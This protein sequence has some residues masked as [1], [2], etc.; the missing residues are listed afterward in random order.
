MNSVTTPHKQEEKALRAAV[1]AGDTQAWR[2]LYDR[3]FEPLFTWVWFR[4]GRDDERT[5]EV[6]Q[7]CW[8]IAVRRIK[9][10]DPDKG[11]FIAWLRGIAANVLH[12]RRRQ[13]TRQAYYETDIS[14][15]APATT[16]RNSIS[17]Q[18]SIVELVA[19][20]LAVLPTHYQ[21][22]LRAK[23]GDGQSVREIAVASGQN[24]K[25]VESLL[26]RARRA[27]RLSYEQ[28]EKEL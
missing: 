26:T 6:V 27:F 18:I 23:Y 19:M 14:C 22:V 11:A 5:R 3:A 12:N 25:A 8:L 24:D 2:A 28:I 15:A 13:W 16:A 7:E 21:E 10:F 17:R 20:T 9:A 4:T 1:L